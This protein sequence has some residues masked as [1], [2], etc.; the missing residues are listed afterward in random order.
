MFR[1]YGVTR[2]GYNS[3][4]RRGKSFRRIEDE[5]LYP[6]IKKVYYASGKVYDSPKVHKTLKPVLTA[7]A[8]RKDK[9]DV[10]RS[11]FSRKSKW[12]KRTMKDE[13]DYR[14]SKSG[15]LPVMSVRYP[16]NKLSF[17]S[18]EY[19]D[20]VMNF[21]GDELKGKKV[22]EIGSGIGRITEKLAK[23]SKNVTCV[24]L[25]GRMINLSISRL[26]SLDNVTYIQSFA[27]DYKPA[28]PH[29]AAISSLVIIHNT[30]DGEYEKLIENLCLIANAI[31]IFEDANEKREISSRTV[32]RDV[33]KL[34]SDFGKFGFSKVRENK[35]SLD[36]DNISFLKFEKIVENKS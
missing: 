14:S 32:V 15:L 2:A 25:C 3:W 35:F 9:K 27:Q 8:L 5:R 30:D 31:Y 24:E 13:W 11:L 23:F 16:Q 12:V 36:E 7:L 28:I 22:V 10:M 1:L 34:V 18:Q 29:D 19:V 17:I 20:A 33:G 21:I 4:R 6:L 26:G